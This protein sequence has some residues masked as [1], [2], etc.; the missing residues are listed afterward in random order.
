M[1]LPEKTRSLVKAYKQ[2]KIEELIMTN[3]GDLAEEIEMGLIGTV[4]DKAIAVCCR[5]SM[6]QQH[7]AEA[8]C[9]H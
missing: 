5:N 2:Q 7:A 4:D 6:L 9:S 1:N 8:V 3:N